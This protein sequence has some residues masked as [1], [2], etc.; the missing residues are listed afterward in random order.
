[1]NALTDGND[2]HAPAARVDSASGDDAGR[3]ENADIDFDSSINHG[4]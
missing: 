4:S 2:G 3:N 1:M